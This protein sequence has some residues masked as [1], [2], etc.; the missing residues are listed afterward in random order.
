MIRDEPA[1]DQSGNK[2]EDDARKKHPLNM[3]PFLMIG[4]IHVLCSFQTEYRQ[5]RK[6]D[7]VKKEGIVDADP[8]H[9]PKSQ[10]KAF[11]KGPGPRQQGTAIQDQ[12]KNE[13]TAAFCEKDVFGS[14]GCIDSFVC[15][16]I[17]F[18][19]LLSWYY[20]HFGLISFL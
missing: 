1:D 8:D 4:L 16:E 9:Q 19:D 7:P 2:R 3:K 14:V 15:L 10:Q 17:F 20:D 11:L 6:Q 5:I 12:D 13:Y 18:L